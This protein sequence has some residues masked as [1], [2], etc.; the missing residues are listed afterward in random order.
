MQKKTIWWVVGV[1]AFISAVASTVG[2]IFYRIEKKRRD[3]EELQN[4]LD[5]VIE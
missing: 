5:C 4:Y 1:V 3:D 2:I